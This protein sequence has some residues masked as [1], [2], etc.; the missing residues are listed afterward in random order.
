MNQ[1][2]TSTTFAR[3]LAIAACLI[4]LACSPARAQSLFLT[5]HQAQQDQSQLA[6]GVMIEPAIDASQVS[7]FWVA[8]PEKRVYQKHD[9]ITIIVDETSS[10][11]S[12]QSLETE[13]DSRTQANLNS[14]LNYMKLLELRLQEGDRSNIDLVDVSATREFTGEG[15]YERKDRFSARI[16]ATV[17]EV[18][19]NGNLVLEATKRIEK[20]D[21]IQ[22]F[23]LSGMVREEDITRQ[24]TVLSSQMA[25]LNIAIENEGDLRDAAKKGII[26]EILDTLFAF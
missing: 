26:T 16:T 17:L 2:P 24:N 12:S 4:A 8:E 3:T 23:V 11:T 13:K 22:H 1:A 25:N 10:Q 14:M 18:K 20:D 6:P 15:D 9:I 21:E 19:P 7:L 5:N